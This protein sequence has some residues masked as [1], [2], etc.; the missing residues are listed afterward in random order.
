MREWLETLRP[1]EL[2]MLRW[3]AAASAAA[4]WF[5]LAWRNPLVLLAVPVVGVGFAA[6]VYR[7]RQGGV[8]PEDD[9]ADL[10]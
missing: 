2:R 1:R 8:G 5:S 10:L 7:S 4:L 9:D 6:F 3:S